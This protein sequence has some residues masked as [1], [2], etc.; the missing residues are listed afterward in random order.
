[1]SRLVI[2][3][4]WGRFWGRFGALVITCA[5]TA[6]FVSGAAFLIPIG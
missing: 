3:R 2:E 4:F 5:N 6:A 1:M